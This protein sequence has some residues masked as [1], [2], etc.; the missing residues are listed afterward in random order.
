MKKVVLSILTILVLS[1]IIVLGYQTMSKTEMLSTKLKSVSSAVDC[2][3]TDQIE[4]EDVVGNCTQT[5][6]VLECDNTTKDNSSCINKTQ[7]YV[8]PCVVDKKEVT[9]TKKECSK[10][11]YH[12]INDKV[13]VLTSDYACSETEEDGKVIMICDSKKDGNG[14]GVCKSGE[15]C[16]KL[17]IDGKD[18]K[19]YEK[20]SRENF[21]ESDSSFFLEKIPVEVEK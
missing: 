10:P 9:K 18:V 21:V 14:D 3:Y 16:M 7:E 17:I 4:Y 1:S 11:K 13:K 5:I 12:L 20:N 8:F 15:S 19:K 2:K 6:T